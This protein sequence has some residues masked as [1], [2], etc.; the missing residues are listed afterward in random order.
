LT[1]FEQ[2]EKFSAAEPFLNYKIKTI[3][4]IS[5]LFNYQTPTSSVLVKRNLMIV[6]PFCERIELKAREDIDC[7]LRIHKQIGF[8]HKIKLPLTGYR[9]SA[10][11]IS[12]D[13]FKMIARTLYCY[14]NTSGISNKFLSI[15]PIMATFTHF[16]RGLFNKIF[17]RG[18]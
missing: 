16:S 3:S 14:Q 18:I 7:W 8:S 6:N 1:R 4:Y 17:N 15:L 9:V 2:P 10:G 11:Q 13:K 12:G 5:Q